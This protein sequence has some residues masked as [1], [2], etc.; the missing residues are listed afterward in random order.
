MKSLPTPLDG[1]LILEPTI[2]DDERGFFF[3]SFNEVTFKATTGLSSITFVQD[4]HSQ[5]SKGVLR[6]LHYQTSPHAQG[7]LI[8]V[9]QGEIWDVAVDIRDE[10]PTRGQW[11]G[12]LLSSKNK[13]Q[14]WLPPGFAHGFVTLSD[15][16]EVLYKAT[17]FYSPEHE[18]CLAW[19]DPTLAIDWQL[20]RLG[21][22]LPQL[23]AKD[24]LG[25]AFK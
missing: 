3:E 1:L 6:G 19:N 21:S 18:R 8:R 17:N 24:K 10:S 5:S 15:S 11:L 9:V 12:V 14:V 25:A 2:F 16:A 22:V 13:K 20:S 23:S 7:K 4:N